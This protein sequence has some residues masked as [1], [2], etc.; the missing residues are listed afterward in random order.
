MIL[1]AGLGTRLQP[2]SDVRAKPAMPV[3]GEPMVRRIARW[4]SDGGVTDVVLNLHHRPETIAAA[5]GDGS[6][7]GV[8]AR[9]SWEQP[10]LLGAAGGPRQALDIVGAETF[11]LVNGDTLTDV[12]LAALGEAHQASGARVTLALVP[13]QIARALRRHCVSTP[14]GGS[15][16]FARRAQAEGSY[17]FVGVQLVAAEVF[18]SIRPGEPAASIGGVYDR[19][20]RDRA[21]RRSRVRL[22]RRVL[23]RGHGG[24][25][26]VHVVD[27]HRRGRRRERRARRARAR[28]TRG[29]RVTRSILW[30]DI[31][32]ARGAVLDE[33]LVTDGVR[34]PPAPATG[35]CSCGKI[36][37]R[38]SHAAPLPVYDAVSRPTTSAASV[39]DEH[40]TRRDRIDRSICTN[41]GSAAPRPPSCR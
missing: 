31:D 41:A 7:L 5:L 6:D 40:A 35:G 33:C 4:L 32:V 8:R 2:L 23:G 12:D 25:L 39:S 18:R 13:Q 21:G 36:H 10:V 29:A 16:A 37:R 11:F 22:R 14:K 1:S 19:A 24:R 15:P 3:G 30:D 27:V 9:Y 28:S 38:V 17:H 34:V 26:L 20:D